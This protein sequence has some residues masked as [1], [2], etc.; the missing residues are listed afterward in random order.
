MFGSLVMKFGA[1]LF[2]LVLLPNQYRSKEVTKIGDGKFTV[3]WED[4]DGGP[5]ESEV[6]PKAPF[7]G[8]QE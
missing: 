8:G 3:K 2:L 7:S 5:E 1:C 6:D 4:P